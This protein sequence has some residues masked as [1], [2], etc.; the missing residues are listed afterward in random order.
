MSRIRLSPLASIIPTEAGVLLRSDLGT[1]QLQGQDVRLFLDAMVPLLDGSRDRDAVVDALRRYSR[2]SVIA[3]LDLLAQH[4]LVESVPGQPEDERWRGQ[5][6]FFQKWASNPAEAATR[7][8]GAR[9]LIAG[10]E[11]WGVVAATELAASGVGTLHL[12]DDDQVQRDDLLSTRSWTEHQVG[13]PRRE[14]VAGNLRETSPWCRVTAG[15]LDQIEDRSLVQEPNTWDLLIGALAGD[16]LRLLRRLALLSHSAGVTSLFGHLDGLDAVVGPVVVPGQTACWNCVRLRQLA[17]ADHPEEAHALQA[18]LLSAR[19]SPRPR[20]YLAPMASL[21]GHCLALEAIKTVSRYTPSYLVGRVLVQNLVTLGTTLHSVI[22]MPWCEICGGAAEGGNPSGGFTLRGQGGTDDAGSTFQ[23]LSDANDPVQLRQLLAG[24]LDTRTGIIRHLAVR[25]PEAS[26][27]ELPV[28]SSAVLARYTEGAYSAD[29]ADMGSGK[30]LT[31]VEAMIGAVGEAIERYSASRYRKGDLQRSALHGLE[32]ECLDPRDLCLYDEAQY[33]RP[34]FPFA[35]FDPDRPIDWT[36]GRWLDTGAP[37]WV[38]ALPAYFDFRVPPEE[39]FCQVT[40]NGLAAGGNLMDAT[41]RAVFELVE[42]DAFM[43]TWLARRAG[44]G[45]LV[46][47]A[48]DPGVREVVRQLNERNVEVEL[49]LLDVGVPIP[50]VMCL[51]IGDG[52]RWPGVSVSLAAHLSPR[53]AARKAILEQGHL[54]PYLSRLMLGEAHPVPAAPEDVRTLT[55]HAL[56]YVPVHRRGAFD[57]LR[58]GEKPPIPLAALPEP[59][60]VSLAVCIERLRA[61]GLR[62]AIAD[63]TSPDVVTGPFRVVRALGGDVQP[64]HFGFAHRRLPCRRLVDML[65]P[66]HDLNPHPHPLA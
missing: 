31:A 50:V 46:D 52:K 18:S 37:V 20:T 53:T 48:L 35:R 43:I 57:F 40:S 17:N 3:F 15:T 60:A 12:L 10:L 65:P 28:T 11:P 24:W 62:V 19:P 42:R 66:G 1:F 39:R 61:C 33:T 2:Q 54:G 29:G 7:L 16:E 30:G 51:G 58:G 5:D 44:Q 41:L 47:G 49:F 63:V 25:A 64:I 45:L 9:I 8:R 13:S 56:F 36:E 32:G 6:A 21:L 14:A 55:D 34:N 59:P 23:A 38:P 26:E 4:G 22:R 27:P